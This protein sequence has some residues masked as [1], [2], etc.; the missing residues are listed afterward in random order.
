MNPPA[1][2]AG[3]E[4][5]DIT[6]HAIMAS[7]PYGGYS[8]MPKLLWTAPAGSGYE[9]TVGLLDGKVPTVKRF[10][11]QADPKGSAL[12]LPTAGQIGP[13]S[14]WDGADATWVTYLNLPTTKAGTTTPAVRVLL[15]VAATDIQ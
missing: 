8:R 10:N 5:M 9:F 14:A 4:D 7:E 1:P 3:T 12:H 2:D 11:L 15:K 13:V 6:T